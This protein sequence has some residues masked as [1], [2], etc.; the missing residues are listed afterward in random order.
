MVGAMW[1]VLVSALCA[2]AV[3]ISGTIAD[4]TETNDNVTISTS[5]TLNGRVSVGR[6]VG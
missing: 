5:V 3:E 4:G 2:G 6:V 1:L